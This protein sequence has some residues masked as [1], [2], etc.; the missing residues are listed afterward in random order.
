VELESAVA[1]VAVQQVLLLRKRSTVMTF[2]RLNLK[3]YLQS[4]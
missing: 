4:Q 3:D 2:R 1:V